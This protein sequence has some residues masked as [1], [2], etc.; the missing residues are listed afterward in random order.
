S[1]MFVIPAETPWK[2]STNKIKVE[3]KFGTAELDFSI[4]Q[5]E[6]VITGFDPIVAAPGS[7]VT[8]F[9]DV[10]D[11]LIEVK[12]DET[13]AEV[14]S[15]T[16]TEIQVKVPEGISSALISVTT[17]GGTVVAADGFG[18][19]FLLYA[20]DALP[21]DFWDGSWGGEVDMANEEVFR[22]SNSIRYEYLDAWG[23]FQFGT[24]NPLDLSEFSALK[25][26][27]FVGADLDGQKLKIVMSDNWD[28]GFEATLTGDE[29]NDLTI[30]LSDIGSPAALS[31]FIVQAQGW[32]I[33][34]VLYIDDIGFL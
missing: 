12:F 26:S 2:N 11:N 1:V 3:T 17:P 30:P 14:V 22:G 7:I 19:A 4:V 32:D 16:S 25:I 8:I 34:T 6:P 20:D 5:P 15:S 24:G 18:F 27:F 29:W 33:N 23:G 31:T 21:A 10:F 28:A 13:I 9:G